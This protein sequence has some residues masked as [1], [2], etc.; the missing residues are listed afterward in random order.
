MTT[1]ATWKVLWISVLTGMTSGVLDIP[2]SFG[3]TK[4]DKSGFQVSQA[5]WTLQ[6][7]TAELR[8][9][10]TAITLPDHKLIQDVVTQWNSTQLMLECLCELHRVVT[11]IMLDITLTKKQEVP[12]LLSPHEWVSLWN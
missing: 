11:D 3:I 6:T 9:C 2:C 10:R 5:G 8:K 4:C 12:L 1:H 7:L